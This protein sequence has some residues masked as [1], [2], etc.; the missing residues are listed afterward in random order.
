MPTKSGET[1][2]EAGGF[3][4]H[5]PEKACPG[6]DP[7]WDPVFGKIMR[8]KWLERMAFE[9]KSSRALGLCVR[10]APEPTKAQASA[11]LWAFLTHRSFGNV[12][13]PTPQ[14]TSLTGRPTIRAGAS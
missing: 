13:V 2:E 1:L 3:P 11:G 4:Q 10:V 8:N 6:L 7:W 14:P 9:E 12:A 5:D